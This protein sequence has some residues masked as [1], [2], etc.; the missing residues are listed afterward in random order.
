VS[1]VEVFTAPPPRPY[2]ELEVLQSSYRPRHSSAEL[3]R[4]RDRLVEEAA[5]RGCDGVIL[6]GPGPMTTAPG[7]S[8]RAYD[9]RP[10]TGVWG[11]CILFVDEGSPPVEV[12]AA[13][14]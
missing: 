6:S 11:T 13:R 12:R 5:R 4:Y 7:T 9:E 1:T 8:Y 14:P 10:L 2:L 3:S